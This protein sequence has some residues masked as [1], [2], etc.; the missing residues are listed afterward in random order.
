MMLAMN[1]VSLMI[2]WVGANQVAAS[3]I[4]VGDMM[5]FMQY[6]MLIIMAFLMLSVMFIML[7]RASVSAGRVADVLE[8]EATI[9]DPEEPKEIS[10]GTGSNIEFK[11]VSF[12]Y[13]NAEEDVIH[14][15]SFIAKKGETTAV[16]GSTGSGKSTLANLILRFYD[17]S[18]GKV[19][20]DGIDVREMKQKSLREKIGYVP[21]KSVL[22]SGTIGSNLRYAD[23]DASDGKLEEAAT[24]AQA[25]DFIKEKAEDFDSNISQGGKN[26]SG[27]QSQ[28]L[29]IARALVKDP[30]ILVLD[31]CFSALDF[32]TDR[33]LRKALK[34]YAAET[35]L[36]IVAQRVGTVMNAE[37]IIVLD[38]GRIAGKGTHSQLM[39]SCE[40]YREIALSQ[41]SMEELA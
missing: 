21:Q 22:F 4:Q 1:G 41:L 3:N 2:V 11:D 37:Q 39:E 15:V 23:E 8:T 31:D 6:A 32:R 10:S 20:V 28:R 35:T 19:L 18:Q 29:S 27:G 16:I 34:E 13:P 17:V 5:A 7:P 30:E 14:D 9:K 24:V 36:F 40:T 33:A 25:I 26:V 38:E 12:R